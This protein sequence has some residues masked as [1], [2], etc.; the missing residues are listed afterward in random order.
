MYFWDP[1]KQNTLEATDKIQTLEQYDS[2][3]N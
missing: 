2:V 1:V 3:K